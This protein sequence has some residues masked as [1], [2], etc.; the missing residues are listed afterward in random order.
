M[1]S[2][3]FFSKNLTNVE[4]AWVILSLSLVDEGLLMSQKKVGLW[5]THALRHDDIMKEHGV[6]Q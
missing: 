4:L 1:T 5:S 2:F 3:A 6:R